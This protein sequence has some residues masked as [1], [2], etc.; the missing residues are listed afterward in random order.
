MSTD[1]LLLQLIGNFLP[2]QKLEKKVKNVSPATLV[3]VLQ[4]VDR[5]NGK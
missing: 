3:Q 4:K 5:T 1:K 2:R